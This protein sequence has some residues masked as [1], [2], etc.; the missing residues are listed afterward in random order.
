MSVTQPH[1][2]SEGHGASRDDRGGRVRV[3]DFTDR[4]GFGID[5]PTD[6]LSPEDTLIKGDFLH[7]E[8]RRGLF[9]HVSD[10][11]EERAFTVTS[12]LNEGLSCIFFLDG[13]VDVRFGDRSS[14]FRGDRRGVLEGAAVMCAGPDSF[15]RTSH[16]R[17]H[18]SHLVVSAAPEWLGA[19][20]LEEVRDS[21]AAR[22]LRDHLFQH[23]WTVTPRIAE[24]VR[25]MVAPS[26]LLPEL[27]SLYLEGR[28]VEI[29]AEAIAAMLHADRNP[30]NDGLLTRR[31]MLRLQHAKELI[32]AG[33]AGPLS[34]EAIAR[35]SGISASGLQRLFRVSEGASIFE[36]VRRLRL[37]RA[38]EALRSG[39][40]SVQEASVIAGYSSPANFATTAF[41]RRF[42][43]TP[44]E[45][46]SVTAASS[47]VR[48]PT[49]K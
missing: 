10:A 9:V 6:R 19:E 21:L 17:Q 1:P 15:R 31:D 30:A 47:F 27:R 46:S 20:G 41:R 22:L 13:G 23:R 36:Y 18:V 26:S 3:R 42:G 35:G 29:V 8:L 5:V 4:D 12:H 14:T 48:L 24:L 32:A 37:E 39:E 45:V 16:G 40:A 7:Q 2:L 28:A 33:L 11:I 43:L 38:F 44:S 49:G 25:Q 34:V